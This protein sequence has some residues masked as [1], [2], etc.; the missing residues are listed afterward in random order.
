MVLRSFPA[1][2][3]RCGAWFRAVD[4]GGGFAGAAAAPGAG[5][6]GDVDAGGELPNPLTMRAVGEIFKRRWAVPMTV[7]VVCLAIHFMGLLDD[8]DAEVSAS[9]DHQVSPLVP[10]VLACKP[11]TQAQPVPKRRG[12]ALREATGGRCRTR[13]GEVPLYRGTSLIRKRPP[14]Y[15]RR[16]SW[17]GC[18]P[19]CSTPSTA[20]RPGPSSGVP[21]GRSSSRCPT[22]LRALLTR[23]PRRTRLLKGYLA[24]KKYPPPLGP[25]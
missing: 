22:V 23:Y 11:L 20:W 13:V 7:A 15:G 17:R 19:R 1:G 2:S 18:T 10:L 9:V 8:P 3:R 14:P 24:H 5:A 21:C 6:A 16:T 4:T 25:P 12:L